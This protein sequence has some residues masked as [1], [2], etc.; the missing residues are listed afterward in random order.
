M[1]CED[2]PLV[3]CAPASALGKCCE[4]CL[5]P[6]PD[7]SLGRKLFSS[8]TGAAHYCS[9]A[10]QEQHWEGGGQSVLDGGMGELNAWCNDKGMNFPRIAAYTL[11]RSLSGGADFAAYWGRVNA[12]CYA[13]PPPP[14]ELPRAHKESYALVKGAFFAAG[15]LGGAGVGDFFNLVFNVG[16]YARFMGTL[17]LNSFS[18]ECPIVGAG[19]RHTPLTLQPLGREPQQAS[20]GGECCSAEASCSGDI[21]PAASSCGE[22]AASLGD[23]PGGTALYELAS[24]ANH[25]CEPNADVVIARGGSLALRARCP[26]TPGQEITITYLDSSLPFAFRS[27]RLHAGYGFVCKCKRCA[28]KL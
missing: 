9:S 6:L 28:A 19:N 10:C 26:V 20:S 14:D 12:L 1:L 25:N 15:K 3:W 18:V 21:G 8:P 23:A 13:T 17:R 7:D 11:A 4:C 5:G 2:R 27:K 22:S 16:T 24:L